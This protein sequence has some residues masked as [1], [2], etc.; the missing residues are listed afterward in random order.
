MGNK[1][2]KDYDSFEL[3]INNFLAPK[4]TEPENF[5]ALQC[6]PTAKA[7]LQKLVIPQARAITIQ[8]LLSR[9]EC[10][11]YIYNA[12]QIGFKPLPDY[13]VEYRNNTRAL[14]KSKKLA[15]SIWKRIALV[16]EPLFAN[17]KPFGFGS[18]GT[19]SFIGYQYCY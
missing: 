9:D 11:L 18:E 14:V 5:A 15:D 2:V 4:E 6:F 19:I 10:H 7:R 17:A 1:Q 13:P 16:A 3:P 12:E 8:D